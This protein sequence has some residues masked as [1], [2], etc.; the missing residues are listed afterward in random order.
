MQRCHNANYPPLPFHVQCN[1]FVRELQSLR[2]KLEN[3]QHDAAAEFSLV[4]LV[5]ALISCASSLKEGIHDAVLTTILSIGLWSCTKVSNHKRAA[6]F[7]QQ[8]RWQLQQWQWCGTFTGIREWT[9]SCSGFPAAPN[10]LFL[11]MCLCSATG[12]AVHCIVGN[13]VYIWLSCCHHT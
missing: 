8:R 2:R 13:A 11:S 4:C 9:K 1:S 5:Q 12:H 7:E 6:G 3:G 10:I